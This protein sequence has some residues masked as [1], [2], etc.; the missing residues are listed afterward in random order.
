MWNVC[1]SKSLENYFVGKCGRYDQFAK[2]Y[3]MQGENVANLYL[4]CKQL[5][6]TRLML[7]IVL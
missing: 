6:K 3:I 2:Q 4:V 1:V 5:E 7:F